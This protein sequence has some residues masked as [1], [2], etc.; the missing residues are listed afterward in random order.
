MIVNALVLLLIAVA[1]VALV[2]GDSAWAVGSA[3]RDGSGSTVD[4][5]AP[6]LRSLA[7]VEVAMGVIAALC[8]L[9][10]QAQATENLWAVGR[11]TEITPAWAVLWWF[12]P[13]AQL[14][15]PAVA[16]RQLLRAS[17]PPGSRGGDSALVAMWWTLFLTGALLRFVGFLVLV[18]TAFT[19]LE[20]GTAVTLRASDVAPGFWMSAIGAVSFALAGWPAIAIVRRVD[21]RQATSGGAGVEGLGSPASP[22]PRPDMA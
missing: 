22:P 14:V 2:A 5:L 16:V 13:F 17:A 11:P 3:W 18:G 4:L 6:P 7:A 15:K 12:V 1:D 8:W 10:W 20:Y 21:T 19:R 9:V